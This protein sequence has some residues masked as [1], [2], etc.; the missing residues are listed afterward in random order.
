[1]IFRNALQVKKE[2]RI[3]NWCAG[4]NLDLSVGTRKKR[5]Q[6]HFSSAFYLREMQTKNTVQ[7]M[8]CGWRQ[9][10]LCWVYVWTRVW[11][12]LLQEILMQPIGSAFSHWNG[13]G[14]WCGDL[15]IGV[16][17]LEIWAAPDICLPGVKFGIWISFPAI[18]LSKDLVRQGKLKLDYVKLLAL[19]SPFLASR[20]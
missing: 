15:K 1:M 17:P 20:L 9:K 10:K 6:C 8:L 12:K 16:C 14:L 3:P 4:C 18:I 2:S 19:P 13:R 11:H 5:D 7:I